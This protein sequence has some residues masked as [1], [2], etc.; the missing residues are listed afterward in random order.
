MSPHPHPHMNRPPPIIY[1]KTMDTEFLIQMRQSNK[2][3]TVRKSYCLG[4]H[5]QNP[6]LTEVDLEPSLKRG[7]DKINMLKQ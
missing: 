4:L 2:C 7:S 1:N 3:G 5:T 6:G